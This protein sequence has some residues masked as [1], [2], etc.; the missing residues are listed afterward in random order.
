[1]LR[2]RAGEADAV[3][4]MAVCHLADEQDARTFALAPLIGGATGLVGRPL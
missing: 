1:M 3:T 4:E 2:L